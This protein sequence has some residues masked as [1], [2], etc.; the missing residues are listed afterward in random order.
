MLGLGVL[1]VC[2]SKDYREGV[3]VLRWIRIGLRPATQNKKQNFTYKYQDTK[4]TNPKCM[5]GAI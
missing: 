5:A 2:V 1:R 3:V 4:S